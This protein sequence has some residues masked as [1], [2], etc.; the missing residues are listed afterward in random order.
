MDSFFGIGLPELVF[1][2]ILAGLVM[3]PQQIRRVARTLG[4]FIG[5]MQD[6]SAQFKDQLNRELDA[7]DSEEMKGAIEDVRLL[8]EEMNELRRQVGSIPEQ[9]I[10]EGRAAAAEGRRAFKPVSRSAPRRQ[11][12]SNGNGLPTPLPVPDDLPTPI[13]VADDPE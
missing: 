1:I 6:I 7:M 11:A 2:L 5:Q 12:D 10:R 4:H 8:R 13:K 3:G 9:Y